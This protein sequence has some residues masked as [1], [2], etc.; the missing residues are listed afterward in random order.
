MNRKKNLSHFF[1]YKTIRPTFLWSN[2][3]SEKKYLIDEF[4]S[5]LS[6]S[7]KRSKYQFIANVGSVSLWRNLKSMMILR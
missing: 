3:G 1:I 2:M 5:I 6:L 4:F 7:N